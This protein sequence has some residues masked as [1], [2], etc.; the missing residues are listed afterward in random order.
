MNLN[1]IETKSTDPFF[2]LAFEE[3]LFKN[4][5]SGD[6]LMLWQNSPTVVVG[7]NQNTEE[8][9][10]RPF[11]E[12]NNIS[13]VRRNTGGGAVY[14]DLGNLNY[15]FITDVKPGE[16]LGME[17]F[18]RPV[19]SA[20]GS[21]GVYAYTSGRNDILVAGKKISG[22]AQS[23]KG[24]RVLHH[25]TLLVSSDVEMIS[26]AL[27]ADPEKF[28]S[29]SV[30]SVSSRVGMLIDYLPQGSDVETV[31]AAILQELLPSGAEILSLSQEELKA[32]R[33]LAENKYRSWD[34]NY[35]RSPGYN[36]KNKA[37]FS[38]GSLCLMLDVREGRI[39]SASL[40]GDFMATEEPAPLLHV[41]TGLRFDRD[42]IGH[43]LAGMDLRPYIGSITAE[44]FM[45]LI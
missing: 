34:W 18:S 12:A 19:C 5:K 25:G 39:V 41:L 23:I 9:I 30:K 1:Y 14:H 8:E 33:S 27:K 20:L 40:S 10:N 38:G 32:V 37:R 44:E 29:K 11:I 43:A 17:Q 22:V 16:E 26:G 21:L 15:S 28:S 24:G 7:L 3:Y 35:G 13:V 2:N 31:K 45:S 36:Y 6:W 4:R 42:D